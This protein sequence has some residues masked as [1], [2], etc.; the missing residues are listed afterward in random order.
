MPDQSELDQKNATFWS[1]LCGSQ[2][3][4]ALGIT[5]D[6]PDAL[7]RFDDYYFAYYPYL[8][9]YVTRHD[10]AGRKVLEIGLGYGTLGQFIAEQGAVYHGL[11]IAPT[12]VEMM[13][14]RLRM[15]G[16]GADDRVLEGSAVDIPFPS[17]TFDY[18]FSIGCLHH[19]GN[20]SRSIGEVHR[21]LKP[22]GTAVL[23]LYNRG[24]WRQLWRVDRRRLAAALRTGQ[25]PSAKKIRSYYDRNF[26]G[27]SAPHTDFTSRRGV[28]LLLSDFSRVDIRAE[29]FDAVR[30]R[31]RVLFPRERVIRTPLP[32]LLGLDLY[33]TAWKGP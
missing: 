13:Q 23:M 15:L 16:D 27:D 30:F 31:R 33:I 14:H 24:S 21:V 26:A 8:K 4:R 3:A 12:P 19:T 5:G 17:E 22:G 9:S 28:R 11:D 7:R 20:L 18:V 25:M 32:R 29:N 1:E 10:L 6:E 2:I